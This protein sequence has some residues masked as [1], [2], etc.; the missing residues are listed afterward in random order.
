MR[1]ALDPYMHRH[2]PLE[3]LP[4]LAADLGYEWIEL[5]PRADF[6]EWFKAP[7]VFPDRLQSFKRS[8]KDHGVQIAS[9]LPM[10]RWASND[11]A[12]RQAAVRHWKRAIE[13]AV[14]M[15]VDTMNSE[16]GR[17]PHPDKGTCYC[18]HT[19]SMIEACED[20]WWRSME[21]LV[22]IL[23]KEG[24]N[25]HIEPHPE[26]WVETLQPSVDL[27][28]TVNSPRVKFLYCAPHTFYFGDD[29]PAMIRECADVLAHVHVA[30]T[31]NH[32]AS[33]GL[34]YIVNPPGSAARVHQHLDIG[35]G[36]VPWDAFFGT[37]AEVGFD[38]I[39]TACVFAWEERA[40]ES[41]RFMRQEM[42]RYVEKFWN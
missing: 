38:G 10:Y 42:Q 24:I 26:D 23:E 13:I 31:F 12:E 17:G 30:D 15:G 28:R 40:E 19:G 14:E 18:C 1:I 33:S 16:F 21:E 2:V 9:L 22:P 37:L 8:L 32:K 29:V 11:E 4:R 41:S 6:L 7:R 20:A 36:E 27:I 34:R 5:S 25:L 3:D 35:Q 39:M